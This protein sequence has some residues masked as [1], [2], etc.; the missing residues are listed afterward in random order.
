MSVAGL[1]VTQTTVFPFLLSQWLLASRTGLGYVRNIAVLW[2]HYLIA[3]RFTMWSPFIFY[4]LAWAIII[5]DIKISRDS[6]KMF[7]SPLYGR[8]YGVV[9]LWIYLSCYYLELCFVYTSSNRKVLDICITV[10][11]VQIT[12]LLLS[13]IINCSWN[14]TLLKSILMLKVHVVYFNDF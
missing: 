8:M 7:Y 5:L 1:S 4:G 9:Y 14:N 6:V 12:T 11:D 3:G 10:Y 2:I 13:L